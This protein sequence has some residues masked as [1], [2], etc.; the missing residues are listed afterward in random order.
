M[1]EYH[2]SDAGGMELLLQACAQ[3]DRAEALKATID[4]DGAIIQSRSGPKAH[5]ALRAEI[6][7]RTFIVKTLGRLGLDIEPLN[8]RTGRPPTQMSWIPPDHAS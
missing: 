5:P 4:R 3:L 2:I 8:Q 6:A 7:A 1:T